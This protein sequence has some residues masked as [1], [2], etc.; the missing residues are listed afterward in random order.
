ME[1]YKIIKYE[2]TEKTQEFKKDVE[3]LSK[4]IMNS[5]SND[6]NKTNKAEQLKEEQKKLK[7]KKF[8]S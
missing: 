4:E 2:D 5:K 6:W 8:Y 1:N 7:L 3:K